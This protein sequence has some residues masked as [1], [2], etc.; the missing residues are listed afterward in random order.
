MKTAYLYQNIL[1]LT[2]FESGC[3][4]GLHIKEG[5]NQRWGGGTDEQPGKPPLIRCEET[6][7]TWQYSNLN[8]SLPGAQINFFFVKKM[9][10]KCA[11]FCY[12]KLN[13]NRFLQ[14]H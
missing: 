3:L 12:I 4:V 8:L 7:S 1:K 13:A 11:T 5:K 14:N 6:Y 10:E 9:K 2:T